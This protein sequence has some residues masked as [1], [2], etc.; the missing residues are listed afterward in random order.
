MPGARSPAGR[1][2]G[3]GMGRTVACPERSCDRPSTAE[4]DDGGGGDECGAVGEGEHQRVDPP[5][6]D[7]VVVVHPGLPVAQVTESD[8]RGEVTRA[9]RRRTSACQLPSSSSTPL[10]QFNR[11]YTTH[12]SVK[13]SASRYPITIAGSVIPNMMLPS[14]NGLPVQYTGTRRRA[15]SLSKAKEVADCHLHRSTSGDLVTAV[16]QSTQISGPR[17]A[18]LLYNRSLTAPVRRPFAG[19]PVH[20][21][22]VFHRAEWTADRKPRSGDV[23]DGLH[24]GA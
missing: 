6:G 17:S 18:I 16:H 20:I 11:P 4:T 24:A 8:D 12:A 21:R 1:P 3:Q 5:A 7:H 9:R 10:C 23:K 14:G 15:G 2:T 22:P 13:P 19:I